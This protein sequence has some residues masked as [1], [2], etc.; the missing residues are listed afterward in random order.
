MSETDTVDG[1]CERLGGADAI[2]GVPEMHVRVLLAEFIDHAQS[3][4]QHA[5]KRIEKYSALFSK[6]LTKKVR[7]PMSMDSAQPMLDSHSCYKKLPE[8]VRTEMFAK[9]VEALSAPGHEVGAHP[10]VELSDP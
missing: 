4:A 9:H 7:R 1:L 2:Q 8:A 10:I 6:L 5:A 3:R